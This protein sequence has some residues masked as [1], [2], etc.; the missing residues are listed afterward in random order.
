MGVPTRSLGGM[1]VT[2]DGERIEFADFDDLTFEAVEPVEA[3]CQPATAE[4]TLTFEADPIALWLFWILANM[5][6]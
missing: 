1:I 3:G 6:P 2:L 5:T 4:L